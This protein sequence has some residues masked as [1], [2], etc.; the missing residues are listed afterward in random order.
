MQFTWNQFVRLMSV[1]VW[2]TI[3]MFQ[4]WFEEKRLYERTFASFSIQ[5]K[6]DLYF[7]LKTVNDAIS[8]QRKLI[9][10]VSVC[11]DKINI[12]FLSFGENQLVRPIELVIKLQLP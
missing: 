11:A 9:S 1:S 10:F 2:R 4:L 3:V 7:H 5:N 8:S 6:K 12:Y